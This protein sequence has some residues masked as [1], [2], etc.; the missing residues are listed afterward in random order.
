[1]TIPHLRSPEHIVRDE[2]VARS[3]LPKWMKPCA[4]VCWKTDRQP[5]LVEQVSSAL[6]QILMFTSGLV[7]LVER[8]S[9]RERT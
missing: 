5:N 4:S 2:M 7:S 8:E 3:L 9:E 1:M 6:N